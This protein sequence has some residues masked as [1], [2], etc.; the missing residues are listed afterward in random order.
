MT[1]PLALKRAAHT[2]SLHHV[3]HRSLVRPHRLQGAWAAPLPRYDPVQRSRLGHITHVFGKLKQLL[4]PDNTKAIEVDDGPEDDDEG[5]D[6]ARIDTSS[7]TALGG[8]SAEAF[9]PMVG[10]SYTWLE[11][12]FEQHSCADHRR[13]CRPF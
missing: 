6:M 4:G 12:S 8:T 10:P 5:S 13:P 2:K 9:G 1:L 7:R 11:P 3:P